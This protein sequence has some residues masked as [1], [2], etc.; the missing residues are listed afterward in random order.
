MGQLCIFAYFIELLLNDK[1]KK[2]RLVFQSHYSCPR[3]AC[4]KINRKEDTFH[5]YHYIIIPPDH[6]ESMMGQLGYCMKPYA[7]YASFTEKQYN[8]ACLKC[9]YVYVSQMKL[10]NQ[11][12]RRRYRQ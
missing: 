12:S 5:R 8:L 4:S 3:G 9:V 10:K 2:H 11:I 1:E 6:F 7:V